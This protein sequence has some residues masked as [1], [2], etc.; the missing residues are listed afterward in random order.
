MSTTPPGSSAAD[1]VAR[2]V[3][4]S[5]VRN[6]CRT[7]KSSTA[8]HGPTSVVRAS[9]CTMLASDPSTCR[10]TAA[11]RDRVS[12]PIMRSNRGGGLHA[13]GQRPSLYL[14]RASA[15]NASVSPPPHPMSTS[16]PPEGSS[17]LQTVA[18]YSGSP[19]SLPRA[20]S[21]VVMLAVMYRSDASRT[22]SRNSA[23]SAVPCIER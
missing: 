7:S 18:R 21:Q 10:A 12:M 23:S 16:V 8:R 2:S 1:T 4:C 17:P 22:R 9:P 14:V 19:R 3:S 5:G 15:S 11:G 13:A 20:I 6:I